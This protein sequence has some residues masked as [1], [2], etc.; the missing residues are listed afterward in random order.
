[1][2][3]DNP[4]APAPAWLVQAAG[5]P[6]DREGREDSIETLDSDGSIQ[7]ATNLLVY[8]EGAVEGSGTGNADTFKLA[9]RVKDLGVSEQTCLDLMMEHWADRCYPAFQ[10]D[11][12]AVLV[13]N[14]YSYGAFGVG[15]ATAEAA[16]ANH[17]TPLE[18]SYDAQYANS[19]AEMIRRPTP[20]LTPE[21]LDATDIIEADIPK[22]QWILGRRY[23]AKFVT[24]IVAPGGVGKSM[25][26]I[27]DALSI[28]TGQSIS[29]EPVHIPGRVWIHNAEDPLDELK[30]RVAAAM[31]HHGMLPERGRLILTSGRVTKLVVAHVV[32]GVAVKHESNIKRLI[33]EIIDRGITVLIGDPLIRL[34]AVKENSNEDMDVVMEALQDV[35][36]ATGCSICIIHH[37]RKLNGAGGAGEMDNARGASSVV[38][39]TRIQ[40]TLTTMSEDEANQYGI[41]EDRRRWYVQLMDA[42]ANMAPPVDERVWLEK[43]SVTLDNGEEVGTFDPA[44]IHRIEKV[45]PKAAE[46]AFI[47]AIAARDF[48]DG[49]VHGIADLVR[50][51]FQDPGA[52]TAV[53][54]SAA[55][56]NNRLMKLTDSI[57]TAEDTRA[58]V[59][60]HD[61]TRVPG[62]GS[63]GFYVEV[64]P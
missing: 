43:K 39:A 10:R 16:F 61:A 3:V 36:E 26:S 8:A 24:Q 60:V 37:T 45:D 58:L 46:N 47:A 21:F 25:L 48:D 15:S 49:H 9:C 2:I 12:L 6:I 52:E 14:S 31:K 28:A 17:V 53:Q 13:A 1:M 27:M 30:L 55:T 29:E 35:A 64:L 32:D 11:G 57:L 44:H 63:H 19:L 51:C 56:L 23:I 5:Q 62:T 22:R 20:M 41:H 42:K 50:S 4:V 18:Y 38:S 59:M 34:H 33:Q 54:S 40:Y 7:A